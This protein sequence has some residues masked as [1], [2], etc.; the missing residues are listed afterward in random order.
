MWG[1][2]RKNFD[3]DHRAGRCR[4][5]E[6]H[7]TRSTSPVPSADSRDIKCQMKVKMVPKWKQRE[8]SGNALMASSHHW[9]D[10]HIIYIFVL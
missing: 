8:E 1:G 9:V 7:L 5:S 10:T 4:G 6:R 2:G 3:P